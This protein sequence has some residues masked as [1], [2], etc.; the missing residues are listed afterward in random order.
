[1]SK[2]C[3]NREEVQYLEE[4]E[5]TVRTYLRNNES[6]PLLLSF[7]EFQEEDSKW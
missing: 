6:S 4:E 5:V 2:G 7:F 3:K 1:M